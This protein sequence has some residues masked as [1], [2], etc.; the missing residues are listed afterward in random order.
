MKILLLFMAIAGICTANAQSYNVSLIPDSLL[1]KA[2]AVKRFEE[3]RVVIKSTSKAVVYH[4]YAVT[5]LNEAGA[6]HASYSNSYDKLQSLE[7]ISGKLYDG[8]GK[9]LKS[10]KKKDIADYSSNDD[11]SLMTDSRYKVHNFYFTQYPYTVEYEDEQVYDGIFFLPYWDPVESTKYSVQ[12]SRFIVEVPKDF[13]IRFKE[14]ALQE[15]LSQT[16][17]ANKT[18]YAW[19]VKNLTAYH[20]ESYQPRWKEIMPSVYLAPTKFEIEDYKGDMTTWLDLGK[21]IN[22]LNSNKQQLPANVKQDVHKLTDGLTTTTEKVNA[23][24]NYMQKNTR[25]ISVQLGIGS[26]QPFDANYVAGKKYGDCK[27]LSNYMVSLLKEANVPAKYV[28]VKAGDGEK[29]LWEDFPSPY[30]NHAIMCVPQAKDTI[31]LECTS[32]TASAGYMGDFTGGR[33]VLL[34][35]DDGGHVVTT[36]VYKATDNL[37]L[38]NVNAVIDEKGDLK[39]DIH[40]RF[41]GIQ[42]E[43]AHGL[44][45][46]ATSKQK[47]EYLNRS[48][49]LPTYSVQKFDYAETKGAIPVIDETLSLTCPNYASISGK[50][51]FV[52]PNFFNRSGNKL[53]NEEKRKYDIEFVTPYIDVDT[54]NISLPNGYTVESTPKAVDL[55]NAYGSYS[56]SFKVSNNSIIV[57]RRNQRNS[58]RFPAAEYEKVAAYFNEIYKADRSRIVLIKKEG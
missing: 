12:E 31:W 16:L 36:P 55:Q 54:I 25:Y 26:W 42:Q 39:V 19:Q 6:A 52:Q 38:R 5:I 1:T 53:S 46:G 33:K 15:K 17:A 45:H 23:L 35:D 3:T 47:E 44:L 4:K 51:L 20:S 7:S 9:E 40:T 28:L 50:R 37:Q 29:G 18:T 24:Y 2:N 21:F 34:I 11:I 58:G 30:F 8:N 32:Q 56:I 13:T 22:A 27:A 49:S 57:L 41:T 48:I 14:I 10:V 43:N